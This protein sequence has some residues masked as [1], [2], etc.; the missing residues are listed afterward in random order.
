MAGRTLGGFRVEGEIGRG[1]MG[2]VLLARQDTL[3]RPA[4]LK[5]I[6]KDLAGQ[7]ELGAL[8]FGTL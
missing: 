7:P 5:R 4:V 6:L 2:V 8:P 3:N 1:G